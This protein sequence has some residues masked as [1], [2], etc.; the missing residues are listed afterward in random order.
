MGDFWGSS[1]QIC[2]RTILLC[3]SIKRICAPP[4]LLKMRSSGHTTPI[5]ILK[6][7]VSTDIS[8]EKARL[9]LHRTWGQWALQNLITAG[10]RWVIQQALGYS[11]TGDGAHIWETE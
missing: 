6:Y 7:S 5:Y 3:P 1:Y 9:L 11:A 4:F 10:Q 2:E 8:V